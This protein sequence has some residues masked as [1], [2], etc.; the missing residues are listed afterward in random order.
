MNTKQKVFLVFVA[1][2]SILSASILMINTDYFLQL[3]M[4]GI[5]TI[6]FSGVLFKMYGPQTYTPRLGT[7]QK[8]QFLSN[9]KLLLS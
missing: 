3:F 9:I 8:E 2:F 4:L 5:W 6:I 1:G 7:G